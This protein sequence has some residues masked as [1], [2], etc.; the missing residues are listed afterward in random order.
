M[1]RGAQYGKETFDKP[2]DSIARTARITVILYSSRTRSRRPTSAGQLTFIKL[3]STRCS[4]NTARDAVQIF[5]R[6]GITQTGMGSFIEDASYL[7]VL[8]CCVQDLRTITF[9]DSKRRFSCLCY[10]CLCRVQVL[11][12]QFTCNARGAE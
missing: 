9:D 5:G 4:Q 3:Y 1:I 6:R 10:P 12:M 8:G 7:L 11:L 2:S